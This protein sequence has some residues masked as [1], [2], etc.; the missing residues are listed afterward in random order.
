MPTQIELILTSN[1]AKT[2]KQTA[3]N[4]TKLKRNRSKRVGSFCTDHHENV[5]ES[6]EEVCNSKHFDGST[7]EKADRSGAQSGE[8]EIEEV[9]EK[10]GC[11]RF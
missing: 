4:T 5:G 2:Y 10:L 6:K 8:D 7:D 11:V 3:K 9:D 1:P